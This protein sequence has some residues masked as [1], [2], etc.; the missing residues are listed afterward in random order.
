KH[1]SSRTVFDYWDKK[2]G[3]RPGPGRTD[4][5]PTEIRHALSDTFMLA[6]DFTNQL[7]F[8]LAGTR[9]CALFGREIKGEIFA[10]LWSEATRTS[11]EDLLT[12]VTRE[13]AGVVAG[14]TARTEDANQ[15]D[16]ELL[17]LPLAH[18]GYARIRILGVLAP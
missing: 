9:V 4:L 12:A 10:E 7:R 5:D 13:S 8:R 18:V 3:A 1:A 15:T 11:V 16:L 2:R 6:A 14:V 17:L